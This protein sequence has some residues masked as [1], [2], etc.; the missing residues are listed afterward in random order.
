MLIAGSGAI[1]RQP[2]QT[3]QQLQQAQQQQQAQQALDVQLNYLSNVQV[4]RQG[5]PQ[6][7][8]QS[9]PLPPVAQPTFPEVTLHPVLP[10]PTQQQNSLLH[11]ILTKTNNGKQVSGSPA[12]Q[13][14]QSQQQ[15]PNLPAHLLP[16]PRST[17]FSPTLARLLTA[18][19]RNRNGGS[20]NTS[21]AGAGGQHTGAQSFA[22]SQNL[23]SML[24]GQK[25]RQ[26]GGG[27]QPCS[28]DIVASLKQKIVP[29]QSRQQQQ[30]QLHLQQQA[31]QQ[32]SEITIT[33]VSNAQLQK[34]KD[35]SVVT[36]VED[37]DETDRL[38]ID[39]SPRPGGGVGG[40]SAQSASSGGSQQGEQ[41][42]ECQGCH[43]NSAQFVCAGC[44]NQW[45]C[46]REC[47]VTAWEEHSDVCSG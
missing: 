7:K 29:Q 34:T 26:S 46:S 41:I 2:A 31:Q 39:E 8:S 36:L 37:E 44:G 3:V 18:P 13:Q 42:P 10:S 27:G 17:S 9:M 11:G 22:A 32:Q 5:V 14:Q 21:S 20:N 30:Q 1:V 45:Y 33:P 43:R 12:Q 23:T 6:V 15:A 4:Q 40:H 24:R 25:M 38:I 35:D 16:H 19:E 28:N 47:Q